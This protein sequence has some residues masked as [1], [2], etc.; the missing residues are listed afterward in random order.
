VRP[1][2]LEAF[3]YR[4]DPAVP[5]FPDDRPILIFDGNCVLCST[6]VQ[7]ILRT[8]KG[9]HFR[10]LSAQSL[11]GTALYRHLGLASV[12]YET[13]ILLEDGHAW[14]KSEGS[15]RVFERLGFPWSL[16]SIGRLLPRPLRDWLYERIARNR[17]RWF[18]VRETCYLPDP[19]QADRFLG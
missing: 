11:L 8:D 14:L 7:F 6:F 16:M 19:S 17:L 12:D 5:S 9:R 15:I 3:S 10:L 1:E 13:N 18:G 2:A 4:S